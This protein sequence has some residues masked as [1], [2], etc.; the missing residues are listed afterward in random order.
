MAYKLIDTAQH[1]WRAITAGELTALV[2]AVVTF[3]N[4][5]LQEETP[6]R[7]TDPRGVR[8]L[9]LFQESSTTVHVNYQLSACRNLIPHAIPNCRF[10][11]KSQAITSPLSYM[12]VTDHDVSGS[13]VDYG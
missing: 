12:M 3:M 10:S 7:P 6:K 9:T 2:P 1:R 8:R 13:G 5:K 4:D 11:T